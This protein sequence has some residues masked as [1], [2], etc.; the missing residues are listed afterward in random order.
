VKK[1]KPSL[2]LMKLK[3]KKQDNPIV[4]NFGLVLSVYV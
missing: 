1:G 4:F 2:I 3:K